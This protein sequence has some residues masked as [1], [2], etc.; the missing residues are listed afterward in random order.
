MLMN[1]LVI[2]LFVV[3]AVSGGSNWLST[4]PDSMKLKDIP[5]I[6]G[7]LDS[8]MI[9]SRGGLMGTTNGMR[10]SESILGQLKSGARVLDFRVI[11]EEG[12]YRIAHSANGGYRSYY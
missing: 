12:E 5:V 11:Y 3:V 2:T 6:P 7:T 1:K 9:W 10:Q 8:G 4:Y